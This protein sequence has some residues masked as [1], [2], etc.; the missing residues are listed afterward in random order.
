MRLLVDEY[1]ILNQ[2]DSELE[3]LITIMSKNESVIR[4]PGGKILWCCTGAFMVL[5]CYLLWC[6][7][8]TF[9]V[10]CLCFCGTF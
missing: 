1:S 5:S 7:N 3:R 9:M 2:A 10:L 6:Q 4:Y 8:A